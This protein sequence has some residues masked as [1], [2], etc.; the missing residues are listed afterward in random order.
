MRVCRF[1]FRLVRGGVVVLVLFVGVR[2]VVGFCV[3]VDDL[4][5]QEDVCDGVDDNVDDGVGVEVFVV[6]FVI[7]GNY[8]L[9]GLECWCYCQVFEFGCLED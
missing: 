9:V 5:E 3:G 6:V 8:D 2:V 7:V 1:G 4:L